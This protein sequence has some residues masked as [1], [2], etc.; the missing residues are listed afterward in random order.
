MHTEFSFCLL[1]SYCWAS[2]SPSAFLHRR[3]IFTNL[4]NSISK[5]KFYTKEDRKICTLPLHCHL[6][7]ENTRKLSDLF[8]YTAESYSQS[9]CKGRENYSKPSIKKQWKTT[10]NGHGLWN[11]TSIGLHPLYN[12]M[13]RNT[14][15]QKNPLFHQRSYKDHFGQVCRMFKKQ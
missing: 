2:Q 8:R 4:N 14:C 11:A 7:R 3:F 15:I 9:Q 1:I 5:Q 13:F 12:V 6:T 10:P